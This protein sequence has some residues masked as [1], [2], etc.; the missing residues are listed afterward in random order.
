M[1][2]SAKKFKNFKKNLEEE[3]TKL[4]KKGKWPKPGWMTFAQ[5]KKVV[6]ALMGKQL[7]DVFIMSCA[8]DA[9][10]PVSC[11]PKPKPGTGG[12]GKKKKS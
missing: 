11:V 3:L 4:E 10:S 12:A 2:L 7:I 1:K 9:R 5:K 6:P 8:C